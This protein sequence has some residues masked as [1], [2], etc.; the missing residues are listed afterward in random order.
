MKTQ[1]IGQS[2]R[3]DQDNALSMIF[4][5]HEY[6]FRIGD[7]D[8]MR[9]FFMTLVSD[10]DH[11]MFLSSHGGVTAGR[12]SKEYSLFPYYTDDKIAD[13][14]DIT[15]SKTIIQIETDAALL[16]WEPF[17]ERYTG[18]Y[19]I[20]R[21]LYKN[22]YNNKVIFEEVNHDLGLT[23]RY[24]WSTSDTFGFVRKS[25][26]TNSAK[27]DCK[28]TVLDG[29]QNILPYGV[30]SDL[31][32]SSSNLVDAYKRNEL[33]AGSGMGIYALSAI[34][35]DKAE[36]S[37]ALKANVAWSLGLDKPKYLVSSLQL[38]RF[39]KGMAV[40]TEH[41]IKGEKGAYFVCAP[42]QLMYNTE[43]QWMIMADVNLNHSQ[44]YNLMHAIGHEPSLDQRIQQDI[45]AGTKKLVRLVASA[46][47]IQR[48][49]DRQK[50]ARHFSNVL[51]NIMRGGIFNDNYQIDKA[52]F[53]TYLNQAN[54]KVTK[55]NHSFVDK[56]EN[57][58]SADILREQVIQLN[59]PDF[60]RLCTEYLTL[61]FSRR[62][63][64]PSIPWNNFTINT[65]H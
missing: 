12:K 8:T 53:I 16:V 32:T 13:L 24:Q 46:D 31:Q 51:F 28:L 22:I 57:T 49:S 27:K 56:L 38:P 64:D 19:V 20:N 55:R 5:D 43:K 47:G 9:S 39:R 40:E 59:D 50:D 21:N 41:D 26:L 63:D 15:G 42:L 35:T 30:S 4:F 61:K 62:H 29:I 52:D 34:V 45:H 6:Y 17:S 11:W 14:A 7:F 36:P 37:E 18:R 10:S 48:T 2:A 25:T 60:N 65:R 33:H 1:Q 3:M 44:I 58:F 23:F 54:H